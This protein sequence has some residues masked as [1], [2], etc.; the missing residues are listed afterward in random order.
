[1]TRGLAKLKIKYDC[2]IKWVQTEWMK[3]IRH[4]TWQ[5]AFPTRESSLPG[6]HKGE[7]SHFYTLQRG[8][9]TSTVSTNSTWTLAEQCTFT[10]QDPNTWTYW[11]RSLL[12]IHRRHV[13]EQGRSQRRTQT[14]PYLN[15]DRYNTFAVVIPEF[16][17]GYMTRISRRNLTN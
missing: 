6:S 16:H 2:I 17:K 4:H 8:T 10:R 9:P 12:R 15:Y 13:P 7:Y 14:V 1:M 11:C 3:N 5:Q